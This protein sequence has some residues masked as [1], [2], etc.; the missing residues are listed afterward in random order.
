MS[1]F[2]DSFRTCLFP[3][4]PIAPQNHIRVILDQHEVFCLPYKLDACFTRSPH[5]NPF[6]APGLPTKHPPCPSC[7]SC[8]PIRSCRLRQYYQGS[9]CKTRRSLARKTRLGYARMCQGTQ[10]G[11]ILMVASEHGSSCSGASSCPAPACKDHLP[12]FI[13]LTRTRQGMG[14]SLGGIPGLLPH[15]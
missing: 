8:S 1:L 3:S 7:R 9:S 2:S 10:S 15:E 6:D 11:C 13:A 5:I 4:G 12:L 14:F